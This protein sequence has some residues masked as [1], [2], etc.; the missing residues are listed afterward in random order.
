MPYKLKPNEPDFEV[1]DGAF[2][3]RHFVAGVIYDN[4]PTQEAHKFEAAESREP[5]AESKEKKV[6]DEVAKNPS[7][8]A[9][10]S[11]LTKDGGEV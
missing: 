6:K 9:P 1:M 7:P 11:P 10:R 8:S 5:R 3:G 2:A 4:I